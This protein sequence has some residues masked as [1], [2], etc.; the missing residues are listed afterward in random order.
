MPFSLTNVY[1]IAEAADAHYGS[2]ERAMTM[3]EAAKKAGANA[4][5][6]QHHIPDEEMLPNIPSS[7]NMREP[8]YE[9]LKRNALTIN[10]HVILAQFCREIEIDY[11]CT[12]FSL[13]AALELEEKISPWAYKIGSGELTDHPTLV[14]IAK[15]NKPMIVSTGMS[16]ISEI[17]E[18]YDLLIDRVPTLILMNCTSAYPPS[19]SDILIGFIPEMKSLFQ[20]ALIGHSDHSPSI[21]T[22]LAAVALGAVVI[23]KHITV[24]VNL[25]GPDESVSITVEDL[26]QLVRGIR[27]ISAS[28]SSQK[29]ILESEQEII[30]WAR[31][32]LVYLSD[33]PA[34]SILKPGLIWGKRPGTGIPSKYLNQFINR[35]LKRD[36]KANTLLSEDDFV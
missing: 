26:A 29:R 3:V 30:L 12:P 2:L 18:T 4:I 22:A 14:E 10:Q 15:F 11:L 20:R 6:F 21:F 16:E 36:V 35:E 31:R 8:L 17:R 28:M 23:E 33:L 5:K 27:E 13:K 25:T 32:S 9:F 34:G 7:S 1:V 24:D 19:P